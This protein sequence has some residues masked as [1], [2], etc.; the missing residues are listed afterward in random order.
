MQ[1][2]AQPIRQGWQN[3]MRVSVSFD[4]P[5][6]R[7]MSLIAKLNIM[8]LKLQSLAGHVIICCEEN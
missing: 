8:Q 7:M 1:S 4:Q 5:I 2:Q 3:W 6:K